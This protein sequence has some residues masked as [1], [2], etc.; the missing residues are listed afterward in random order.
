MFHSTIYICTSALYTI[1][2]VKH[3]PAKVQLSLYVQLHNLLRLF[4]SVK[5]LGLCCFIKLCK[6]AIEL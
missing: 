4:P 1:R 3:L 2:L 6:L 5:I